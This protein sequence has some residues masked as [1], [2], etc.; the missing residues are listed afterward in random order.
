M[1]SVIRLFDENIKIRFIFERTLLQ[2]S[3]S[4]ISF[5][6]NDTHTN[7]IHRR[8]SSKVVRYTCH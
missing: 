8:Y 5:E 6:T 3:M 1:T 2:F 7:D 4:L